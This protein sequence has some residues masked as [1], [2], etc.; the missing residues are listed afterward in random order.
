[1]NLM[2]QQSPTE[3]TKLTYKPKQPR[4]VILAARVEPH[5]K[6]WLEKN[7]PNSVSHGVS[8]ILEKYVTKH[9]KESSYAND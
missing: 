5:I 1:M 2:K 8:Y 7:F 9:S 6:E 3:E 4:R